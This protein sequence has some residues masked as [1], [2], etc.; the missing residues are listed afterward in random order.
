MAF[1]NSFQNGFCF[2]GIANL[3]QLIVIKKVF[4][5]SSWFFYFLASCFWLIQTLVDCFRLFHIWILHEWLPNRD[6]A[7][8]WNIIVWFHQHSWQK[9]RDF[10]SGLNQT[11]SWRS[12]KWNFSSLLQFTRKEG[13]HKPNSR[14]VCSSK[15][16]RPPG[17]G[18]EKR[19]QETTP[20]PFPQMKIHM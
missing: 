10:K 15:T 2:S 5:L 11:W 14:Q 9:P 7:L 1:V 19:I 16:K 4:F 13:S 3:F 6:N 20:L 17:I 12:I 18:V 8:Q